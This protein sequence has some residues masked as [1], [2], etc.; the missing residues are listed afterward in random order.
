[1]SLSDCDDDG[2]QFEGDVIDP[3]SSMVILKFDFS[4]AELREQKERMSTN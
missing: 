2:S 4:T 3:H 1:L